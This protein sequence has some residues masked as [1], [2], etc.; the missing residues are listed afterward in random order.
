M[1]SGTGLGLATTKRII[2]AHGGEL[3][4][5]SEVGVGSTFRVVLPI[6]SE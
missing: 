6:A 1:A 4:V 2:E 3:Q 5:E